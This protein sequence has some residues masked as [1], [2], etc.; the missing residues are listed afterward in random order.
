MTLESKVVAYLKKKKRAI[1]FDE[2]LKEVGQ[3]DAA[4]LKIREMILCGTIDL[5]ID[6]KL[7]LHK[8]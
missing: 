5:T 7:K 8:K 4:R 1:T 2:L 6:W 3:D